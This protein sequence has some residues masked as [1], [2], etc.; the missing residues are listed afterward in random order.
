MSLT[1]SSLRMKRKFRFKSYRR[2]FVMV[3]VLTECT[4]AIN[5]KSG[6]NLQAL[7]FLS[8]IKEIMEDCMTTK[9][10]QMSVTISSAG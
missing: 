6:L 4:M 3:Q 9:A 10:Q 7:G 8:A 5:S 1:I 2:R